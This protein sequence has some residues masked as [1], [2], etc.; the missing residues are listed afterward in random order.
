MELK[1][2]K[3]PEKYKILKIKKN[4]LKSGEFSV[5]FDASN[6]PKGKLALTVLDS[7]LN[8]TVVKTDDYFK[9]YETVNGNLGYKN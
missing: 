3:N 7:D 1:S 5:K 8:S 2:R 9:L 6:L 4:P